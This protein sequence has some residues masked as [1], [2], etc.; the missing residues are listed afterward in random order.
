MLFN[1]VELKEDGLYWLN[2]GK[3]VGCLNSE[4]Y[5]VFGFKGMQYKEHREVFF[6]TYGYYP[7]IVDHKNKIKDDNRPENLRDASQAENQWNRDGIK[8][9][10]KK[11]DKYEARITVN[12]ERLALGTFSCPTMAH[13]SYLKAA[14][15]LYGNFYK[16]S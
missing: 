15:K 9:W 16:G 12:G 11:R 10:R 13:L 5:R 8:G 4:G 3:R 7:E 2:T 1:H 6:L 14:K